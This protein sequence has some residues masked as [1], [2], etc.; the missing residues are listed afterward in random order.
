MSVA[1]P[2]ARVEPSLIYLDAQGKPR[3]VGTGIKVRIVAEWF[4]AGRTPEQMKEAWAHVPLAGI[5]SAIAYYL[6]HQAAI[7]AEIAEL[8]RF[9][10]ELRASAEESPGR[11]KLRDLGLRP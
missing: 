1:D 9:A 3:I 6:D 11:R 8:Q 2:P 5:Y 10:D 7:D 4:R